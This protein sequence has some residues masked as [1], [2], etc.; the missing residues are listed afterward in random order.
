MEKCTDTV[1]NWM[2]RYNVINKEDKELYGFFL[3]FGYIKAN[4]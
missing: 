4:Y 3:N 2:V 1:V